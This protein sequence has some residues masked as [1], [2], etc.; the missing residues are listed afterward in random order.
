MENVKLS[1]PWDEYAR[2]IAEL[3]LQDEEIHVEYAEKENKLTI[4]V[5]NTDKYEALTKIL[6]AEKDFGGHI[7]SIEIVPANVKEEEKDSRYYL[8]KLFRGNEAVSEIVDTKIG[9][10]SI[11]YIQFEKEVIQFWNDNLGD[12]HGIKSTLMEDIARDIFGETVNVFFG[13]DV[14]NTYVEE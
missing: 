11:T 14:T 5:D 7:L 6:P 4:W 13:T 2:K 1:P 12:L 9:A 3:F 8:K 10:A